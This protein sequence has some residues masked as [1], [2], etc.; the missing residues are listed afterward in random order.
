[1]PNCC[2]GQVRGLEPRYELPV[3]VG[4]DNAVTGQVLK[5]IDIQCARQAQQLVGLQTCQHHRRSAHAMTFAGHDERERSNQFGGHPRKMGLLAYRLQSASKLQILQVTYPAMQRA[6]GVVGGAAAQIILVN[7]RD[8]QA[9]HSRI[10]RC[11]YP[12]SPRTD[13]EQIVVGVL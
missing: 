4:A 5:P 11:E 8:L 2:S 9:T 13:H 1:M 3:A 6:Q 12:M 10:E 7:Q